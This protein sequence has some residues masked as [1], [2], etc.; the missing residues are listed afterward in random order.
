MKLLNKQYSISKPLVEY[1]K[2]LFPNNLPN[3]RDITL[4]DVSFLQGQQSVIAKLEELYDQEF[5]EE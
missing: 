4:N 5:E 2:G 1:L 3:N